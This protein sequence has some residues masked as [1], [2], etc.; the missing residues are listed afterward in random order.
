MEIYGEEIEALRDEDCSTLYIHPS[1]DQREE[2]A[3]LVDGPKDVAVVKRRVLESMFFYFI[4]FSYFIN[5][6]KLFIH[7]QYDHQYQCIKN[8][9]HQ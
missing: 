7:I 4:T 6:E 5:H 2:P 8:I 3:R 1:Y 9:N